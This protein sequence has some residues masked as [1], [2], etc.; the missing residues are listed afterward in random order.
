VLTAVVAVVPVGAS[1]A[2]APAATARSAPEYVLDA[3]ERTNWCWAAT[4]LSVA[5]LLGD[6][7]TT[8]NQFCN[9]AF[10]RQATGNC[11]N[12]QASLSNDQ[13]AY[14][15]LKIKPGTYVSKTL[16]L[17][18]VTDD[19]DAGTA[20]MTRI[21][22]ASGGGHMM[23]IYGYDSAAD[24]IKWADPWGSNSRYNSGTLAFYKSNSK[25][26]WT[27]SLYGIGR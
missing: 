18:T 14:K 4:G 22:W 12:D 1:A 17:K 16:D 8:Q 27:H 21:Q 10:N 25:W 5:K 26:T 24:K 9:M 6:S 23:T 7:T 13:T 3:Q 19:I 15:A 20:I 11:P 2:A